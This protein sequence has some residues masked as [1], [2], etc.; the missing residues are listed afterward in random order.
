MRILEH[1]ADKK[2][3]KVGSKIKIKD[4]MN[5]CTSEKYTIPRLKTLYKV[6]EKFRSRKYYY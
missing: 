4:D 2:N 1:K 3:S 6:L 5:D